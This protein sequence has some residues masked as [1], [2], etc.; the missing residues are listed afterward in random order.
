LSAARV[1]S[2]TSSNLDAEFSLEADEIEHPD[3]AAEFDEQIDVA[4]L[5]RF[6]ASERTEQP[7]VATPCESSIGLAWRST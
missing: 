5:A 2:S 3:R 7:Q 4:A 1:T 6:V